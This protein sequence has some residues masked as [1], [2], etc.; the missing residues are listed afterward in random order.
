MVSPSLLL[1]PE[2][3]NLVLPRVL[4]VHNRYRSELPS[5]E[6]QAVDGQIAL[7]RSAGLDVETYFRS[8][9]EIAAFSRAKRL[10]LAIRPTFSR[11]DVAAI[12]GVIGRFRPDVVHLHNVYPLISPAVI[13]RAKSSDCRVVQTVHNFRHICASGSLFRDGATCTDCLGKSLPWPAVLHGC[14]RGSRMQSLALGTAIA[15]HRSTWAQVDRFLAVSEFV[16]ELLTTAGIPREP[17]LR[18][19]KLGA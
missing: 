5:G 4:V 19:A 10:E 17:A 7:L 9:D 18:G 15:H 6:N 3:P 14:Y 12:G 16:A 1:S 8:S 13:A 11:E 2:A